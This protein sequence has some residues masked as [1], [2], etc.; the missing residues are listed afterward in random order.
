MKINVLERL[1]KRHKLGVRLGIL[2]LGE[3]EDQARQKKSRVW[4]ATVKKTIQRL[5]YQIG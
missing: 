4:F 1:V 2:G 3:G 5:E